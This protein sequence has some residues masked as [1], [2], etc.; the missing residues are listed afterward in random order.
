MKFMYT[1]E[2][3]IAQTDGD[4]MKFHDTSE[5]SIAQRGGDVM[6]TS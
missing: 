1:G 3:N 5:H 4:V 6:N 2:H